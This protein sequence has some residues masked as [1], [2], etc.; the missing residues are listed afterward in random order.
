MNK[1]VII[2][3]R[4]ARPGDTLVTG[5]VYR[6]E[7]LITSVD[8]LDF[9]DRIGVR[10]TFRD[11]GTWVPSSRSWSLRLTDPIKVRKGSGPRTHMSWEP[12]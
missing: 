5:S 10:I 11:N 1:I 12:R 6:D 3:A 8:R 7:Y 4:N 9:E 2:A